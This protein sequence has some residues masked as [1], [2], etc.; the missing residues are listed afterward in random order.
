MS[1][2]I[3]ADPVGWGYPESIETFNVSFTAS[4]PVGGGVM[5]TTG[6]SFV[7]IADTLPEGQGI[8]YSVYSCAHILMVLANAICQEY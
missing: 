3:I 7:T 1:F 5:R 2:K 6:Q 8:V 4:G